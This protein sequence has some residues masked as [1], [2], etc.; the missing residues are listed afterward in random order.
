M[1]HS[2]RKIL[3]E[4]TGILFV[5]SKTFGFIFMVIAVLLC[6]AVRSLAYI[7]QTH[8][9]KE[10]STLPG[11]CT[12]VRHV[13]KRMWRPSCFFLKHGCG[14][15]GNINSPVCNYNYQKLYIFNQGPPT[16]SHN[17]MHF[18]L[19]ERRRPPAERSEAPCIVI[20]YL[21]ESSSKMP[22]GAKQY[23]SMMGSTLLGPKQCKNGLRILVANPL[24]LKPSRKYMLQK[25]CTRVL[26]DT[27]LS[28]P[29]SS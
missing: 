18:F 29:A 16:A 9:N 5:L 11:V 23:V 17:L 27:F 19:P 3:H 21:R 25:S 15:L 6:R 22:L 14:T 1:F 2:G 20:I 7:Q 12:N 26:D 13:S 28:V 4:G 10:I 8:R 24:L